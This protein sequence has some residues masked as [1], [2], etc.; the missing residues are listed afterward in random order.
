MKPSYW[1]SAHLHIKYAALFPHPQNRYTHFLS[2][3]K[4]LQKRSCLQIISVGS[5][6]EEDT[7]VVRLEHDPTWLWVVQATADFQKLNR[8]Y[9]KYDKM[10]LKM[11]NSSLMNELIQ[12]FSEEKEN[13]IKLPEQLAYLNYGFEETIKKI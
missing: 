9:Y 5:K 7:G 1:F 3:D 13:L 10:D 12:R 8:S 6:E 4:C 2:L 11:L